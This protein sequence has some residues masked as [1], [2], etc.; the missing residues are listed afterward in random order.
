METYRVVVE[1]RCLP[2]FDPVRVRA[3]LAALIR[4]SEEVAARMLA[5]RHVVVRLGEERANASRYV[6][7]LRAAG[8]AA[9][10]APEAAAASA[11]APDREAMHQQVQRQIVTQYRQARLSG[12]KPYDAIRDA[13]F[14][15]HSQFEEDGIILYVLATIGFRTRKVVEM[16]CGNGS[17][18][19][20]TNLILNHG[21][22]GHL[23]DGDPANVEQARQFFGSRKDCMLYLPRLSSAWITAENVNDLLRDSGA[24]G[25]V[26]FFSLDIDGN[27]Y[28]VWKAIDAIQP[29]LLCVE[30]H[31]VIPGDLS[32]T[33]RYRPDFDCWSKEGSEQDYRGV[34]LAAMRKLCREK[35]YRMI[36][37]HRHGFNVFFLREDIEP[38]LFP[39]VGIEEI[40]DNHWTRV[41]QRERWPLVKHMDWVPV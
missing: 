39:E 20:A 31:N 35:G 41:A 25:E 8:V 4:Q 1:G 26:D 7:A 6:E 12:Q 19:M 30:T 18:C 37:S 23:F 10:M 14:R 17:E 22:D 11:E 27:D 13:G 5:G 21:F 32:L 40:H 28:W 24:A 36:G 9:S 29:R 38:S 15:C 33:I 3:E 2:G 16:C 34:S